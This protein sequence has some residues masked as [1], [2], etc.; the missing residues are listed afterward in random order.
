[1]LNIQKRLALY[2][3]ALKD[4]ERAGKWYGFLFKTETHQGFCWY[5]AWKHRITL[6]GGLF[7][8]RLPELYQQRPK[9]YYDFWFRQGDLKPRIEC[10]EKAIKMIKTPK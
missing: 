10:L 3:K 7:K 6:Q 4:Y 1:M 9:K 8:S 5:F 2:K